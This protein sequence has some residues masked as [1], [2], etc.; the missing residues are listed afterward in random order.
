MAAPPQ[1][2]DRRVAPA[3]PETPAA[4]LEASA[5]EPEA[6]N[7]LLAAMADRGLDWLAELFA[8]E[9]DLLDW[10]SVEFFGVPLV[11]AEA[12]EAAGP[13]P[14]ASA[15]PAGVTT[16]PAPDKG[17][18]APGEARPQA[19]GKGAAAPDQAPEVLDPL[20]AEAAA[21]PAAEPAPAPGAA[22]EP[23]GAVPGEPAER[24]AAGTAVARV[25]SAEQVPGARAAEPSAEPEEGAVEG[26]GEG[27][28]GAWQAKVTAAVG[29]V[30]RCTLARGQRESISK[31]GKELAGK[32][33]AR[34]SK[35]PDEAR[36]AVPKP[37][38]PPDLPP[39]PDDETKAAV[40]A[41]DPKLGRVHSAHALPDLQTRP[42]GHP[43]LIPHDAPPAPPAV[44]RGK[45]KGHKPSGESPG[46]EGGAVARKAKADK[47]KAVPEAEPARSPTAGAV[48]SAEA[49]EAP[50]DQG[51]VRSSVDVAAVV[52]RLL[53]EPERHA[54]RVVNDAVAVA[55]NGQLASAWPEAGVAL[56]PPEQPRVDQELRRVAA[57]VGVG[58]QAL[59]T[60]IAAARAELNAGVAEIKTDV[61]QALATATSDVT[62]AGDSFASTI[63][64]WHDVVDR[65]V[66][67]R[68]AAA[69]GDV[70]VER[71]RADRERLVQM[72]NDKA[73]QGIVSYESAAEKLK[74]KLAAEVGKQRRAYEEAARL[75]TEDIK[76]KYAREAADAGEQDNDAKRSEYAEKIRIENR[77]VQSFLDERLDELGNWHFN[78]AWEI[79]TELKTFTSELGD[80]AGQARDRIRDW[81]AHRIGYERS[82]FQRLL[83]MIAD[84][85]AQSQIQTAAWAKRRAAE[86][87]AAVDQDL[88][89]LQ[90]EATKLVR[91]SKEDQ[92][93]EF[94]SLREDQVMILN[95]FF[96]SK[97]ADLLGALAEGMVSRLSIQRRPELLKVIDDEVMNL[98]EAQIEALIKIVQAQ[99]P[100]LNVWDR[101]DQL[102]EAFDGPGTTESEVFTAL[103]N[104]TPIGAHAI[105]LAYA[106]RHHEDLRGRLKS[107]LDDWLT[108]SSHDLDRATALLAG[109]TADAVAIELDQAMHANWNGLD[110]GGTDEATIFE[111]LRNKS[112]KEI[113]EIKRAY[114]ERYHKDLEIEVQG[115]LHEG[116][117]RGTHDED[118]AAALFK[119]DTALADVIAMDQA[120]H[121]GTLGLGLGTDRKTLENIYETNDRELEKEADEKGWDS[122]TLDRK[123][124]ERRDLLDAKY[125]GRYDQTLI[126]QFKDEMEGADL[127]L[128]A[129]LREMEWHKV[130]AARIALEHNSVL[131]ADDK[132][133]NDALQGKYKRDYADRKRDLLLAIEERRK[134]DWDAV[135]ALSTPEAR[136][137]AAQQYHK[138]WTPEY[139]LDEQS[140][141][142]KQAR[143]EATASAKA[144]FPNLLSRYDEAYTG[145]SGFWG[146]E[147]FG[148]EADVLHDTQMTQHEKADALIKGQGAVSEAQEVDF[149]IRGLGTDTDIVRDIFAGK[150]KEEMDT[151]GGDW[152]K[153]APGRKAEE[154][155]GFVLGDFSGRE[156][157]EMQEQLEHGTAR[158]PREKADRAQRLL[159]FEKSS[160]ISWG[161]G[162]ERELMES[163]YRALERDAKAYEENE[164][165][166]GQ[167]GYDYELHAKLWGK[168]DASAARFDSAVRLHRHSV[169]AVSDTVIQAVGAAVAVVVVVVAVVATWGAASGAIPGLLAT[170]TSFK[171]GAA[172]A[173]G[174]MATTMGLKLAFRG[175]A[176][177]WEEYGV[178]LAVGAVDL[179]TAAMAS[180]FGL[181]A[182]MLRNSKALTALVERGRLGR[183]VARG[184][185][186]TA[187]GMA[188]AVP[189]AVVGQIANPENF[190]KGDNAL[191]NVLSGAAVQVGIGGVTSGLTGALHESLM[192]DLIA[193]R[194][195]PAYQ[196]EMYQRYQANRR[197]TSR[198][199]FLDTID[200]LI[201]H[202][203]LL[204]FD[205]P[206]LQRQMRVRL[207]EH[208]PEAQR[209]LY[210]DVPI[211][212]MPSEEFHAFSGGSETGQAVT[213]IRNGKPV[214]IMRGG[215]PLSQLA[216]EGPHLQQI[217]DPKN[218]QRVALLAEHRMERWN[219]LTF[220]EQV[221]AYRTKVDLEIEAHEQVLASLDA[222]KGQAADAGE[223]AEARA[224]AQQNLDNLRTQRAKVDTI[225][226]ETRA[227][228]VAD[229]STRPVELEFLD[230]PARLF[231]KDPRTRLT[232]DAGPAAPAAVDEARKEVTSQRKEIAGLEGRLAKHGKLNSTERTRL[233]NLRAQL[234]EHYRVAVPPEEKPALEAKLFDPLPGESLSDYRDRL[235]G[236]RDEVKRGVDPDDKLGLAETYKRLVKQVSSDVED[237]EILTL[238]KEDLAGKIQQNTR[239]YFETKAKIKAEQRPPTGKP[240]KDALDTL[241]KKLSKLKAQRTRL[242]E[243][244]DVLTAKIENKQQRPS[245]FYG[246][247]PWAGMP[248]VDSEGKP[249]RANLGVF[250]E[251]EPVS[252]LQNAGFD[253]ADPHTVDPRKVKSTD[254]LNR[255]LEHRRGAQ[256]IDA[257]MQRPW[258][259]DSEVTQYALGDCKATADRNPPKPTGAGALK[260]LTGG[261]RQLSKDWIEGHLRRSGM[262]ERNKANIRAGLKKP[263]E[264]V[265]VRHADG[266]IDKVIVTK[267]YA[268]AFRTPDGTPQ[269]K[270]FLVT[271]IDEVEVRI[272]GSWAH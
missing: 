243:Q 269:V 97:G 94:A 231:S 38:Q 137:E 219:L 186:Q 188:Q 154:F 66:E 125:K 71:I 100:G 261:E 92:Q 155:Q 76:A 185:V 266:T 223:W 126:S 26:A 130:D 47:A 234:D 6:P 221:E 214:V 109:K 86:S 189:G 260:R 79:D 23:G 98:G 232:A 80:A 151:L 246:D 12:T 244:Q 57:A 112:P 103:D 124:H 215:A 118:R 150:T 120:M 264:V 132:V 220:D 241:G 20:A 176:Y 200:D 19:T 259:Q 263:G 67:D 41:I 83:D 209:G 168:A 157:Q 258:P 184:I 222:Q 235:E 110:L 254:D 45:A 163:D 146:G 114:R 40:A 89:F 84:W 167:P 73:G 7:S 8:P 107:E 1:A 207:L 159:E 203:T 142:L 141:A 169:D 4:Q 53:A 14:A 81:A 33:T 56:V 39:F 270:F 93:R 117:V 123:K 212:V 202:H 9:L 187:E 87:A 180:R 262:S 49:P 74:E 210:G 182:R 216:F 52:A 55:Y 143:A 59:N 31:T 149:A 106:A 48:V 217:L 127:D 171:F 256:D 162:H 190:R 13:Q 95:S 224:Q 22:P 225:T 134:A 144:D 119:S 24:A 177:G 248:L 247:K 156:Y 147:Y 233:E 238:Y 158:T 148:L 58:E 122:V 195:N 5:R 153:L 242:H 62:S 90:D 166:V 229:P 251:L 170:V 78:A 16:V 173:L 192:P 237:V 183:V 206:R 42:K 113:A 205:D 227:A 218:A 44:E 70:D 191:L 11:G 268:Q 65:E 37:K 257:S 165:K 213:V 128:V 198:A 252:R 179:A 54:K 204:G 211:E 250:G 34:A 36:Q 236:M 18:L 99:N 50:G 267:F 152:A 194:T 101:V 32:H 61:H 82:W 35:L 228:V 201:A 172:V 178:D 30:K 88:Q 226:P 208:I 199:E 196:N 255:V 139:I 197:G 175:K 161:S 133:I 2:I 140:R 25:P 239:D 249:I 28:I 271:D 136:K 68:A 17:P 108:W 43:P 265:E 96:T 145:K 29:R 51:V 174:T 72:V 181:S 69:R 131:Y 15:T 115:E 253:N 21:G 105:E 164:K 272:N 135:L 46:V 75:D 85:A 64:S 60:K 104:L 3:Q 10:F 245:L 63:A 193:L 121:G 116:W 91:M 240:N 27:P 138:K 111:A 230:Q 160:L 77:P 129:G 102:W